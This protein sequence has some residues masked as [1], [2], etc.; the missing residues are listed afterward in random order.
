MYSSVLLSEVLSILLSLDSRA[1]DYNVSI[2]FMLSEVLSILL[3]TTIISSSSLFSSTPPPFNVI[4]RLQLGLHWGC[5]KTCQTLCILNEAI[6]VDQVRG[7]PSQIGIILLH[8]NLHPLYPRVMFSFY[9]TPLYQ[10]RYKTENV[11]RHSSVSD[12]DKHT[13]HVE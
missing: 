5:G 6:V 9:P 2:C 11:F 3:K 13:V 12:R 1:K 8:I 7:S 10:V 4:S